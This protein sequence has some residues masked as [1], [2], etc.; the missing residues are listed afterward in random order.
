MEES[1]KVRLCI[2]ILQHICQNKN[3]RSSILEMKIDYYLYP[4]LIVLTDE[5]LKI[6]TLKLFCTILEDGNLDNLKESEILPILLRS[7]DSGSEEQQE[8][9]LTAL[10]HILMGR[11]L[12]YAV[13]T[14]DRFQA[15]D[16]V[17]SSM[18]TKSIYSKNINVL[19]KL[20]VIYIRMCDKVNVI[21][22]IREKI[23]EGIDS[24][25]ILNLCAQDQE[26]D[27]LRKKF[28]NIIKDK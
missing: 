10:H 25:D 14:F 21:Q 11:G 7:V 27:K 15:I 16:V 6:S 18:I 26:L 20:I 13:Q 23:P 8:L 3:L 22:K 1:N 12:D 2:D 24:K 4:F 9:S 5:Q 17:L 19:K 28:L